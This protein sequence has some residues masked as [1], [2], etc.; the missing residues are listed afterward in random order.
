[1]TQDASTWTLDRHWGKFSVGA[2][3]AT[4]DLEQPVMG[5][6]AMRGSAEQVLGRLLVITSGEAGSTW[7]AKLVDGYVRG[8]DLVATYTGGD[9]WP[10]RPQIYWDVETIEAG[11]QEIPAITLVISIQTNLLDTHPRI[12]VASNLLCEEGFLVSIVGDDM[13]IDSHVKGLQTLDPRATACGLVW[14]LPG[15]KTSY[16]EIMP[17]ADF[18]RLNVARSDTVIGSRWELFAEFLEKGVIR[19]SRLQSL[20]LPRENDI[21]LTAEACQTI[22]KR[23]LPLTT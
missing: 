7:P 1:L 16:A 21:Q 2:I 19:R 20:F 10:Y 18:R 22:T 17:T 9:D 3:G 5:L 8:N 14:R 11:D 13:L 6:L 23:P 12:V 4:V 15:T